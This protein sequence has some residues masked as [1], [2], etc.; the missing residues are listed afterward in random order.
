[1]LG[2][3]NPVD[4]GLEEGENEPWGQGKFKKVGGWRRE[5]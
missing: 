3:E 5:G 2:T 4:K 1:M